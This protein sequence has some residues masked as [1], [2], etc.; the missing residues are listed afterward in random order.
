V[1]EYLRAQCA[2]PLRLDEVARHF[3][4]S[5]STLCHRYQAETGESP[6]SAR[7]R[8]RIELAKNLLLKGQT[9]KAVALD[10]GF[11]DPYHLSKTFKQLAGLSPRQF[12]VSLAGNPKRPANNSGKFGWN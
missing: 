12:I 10:T 3:N 11:C 1:H 7:L 5:V 2:R 8:M 4:V 9:L 6:M